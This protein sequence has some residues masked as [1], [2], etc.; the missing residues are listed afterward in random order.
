MKEN[1]ILAFLVFYPFLG[2]LAAYL[3]GRRDETAR[4]YM[5]DFITASECLILVVLFVKY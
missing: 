2:G 4:D 1:M 5:A 3:A